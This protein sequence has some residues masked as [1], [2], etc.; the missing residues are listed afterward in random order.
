MGDRKLRLELA[1]H[2]EMT[3]GGQQPMPTEHESAAV[4]RSVCGKK[5]AQCLCERKMHE[6]PP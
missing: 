4:K 1:L 5:K 3:E 2:L 6:H